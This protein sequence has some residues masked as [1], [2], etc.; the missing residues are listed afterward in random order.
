[1]RRF[2]KILYVVA[3]VLNIFLAL[4][5]LAG[6]MGLLTGLTP[7][8][9]DMLQGSPFK[10]YT[11]PAIALFVIVGGSAS[12]AAILLIRKSK[13]A[14]LF[15]VTAAIIIMFFEFVEVMIIGSPAGIAQM[16]QVFYFGLGIALAIV[17]LG[18]W[19]I[20]LLSP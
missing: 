12:W 10:D 4:T 18:V 13:F 15:S 3:V 14:L 6:G 16:L 19:F 8:P 9:V 5:A 17:S 2:R 11:L 1:M 20:D 7:L